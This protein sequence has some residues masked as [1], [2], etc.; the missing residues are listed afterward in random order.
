MSIRV[1]VADD[2]DMV[3]SGFRLLLAREPDI[4][5]VA[6]AADG[7]AAV[8]E[9]ARN[10]PDVVL[11]DI[12][13][14]LLDGLEA[15]R[16]IVATNPA[17]Q[18]LILTTFD[19]DAYLYEALQAGAAGFMLKDAPAADLIEAI[20][21]LARGDALLAP[22]ITRRVIAEFARRRR[23]PEARAHLDRLT[24][25]EREVLGLI[26]RGMSNAEIAA[27]LVVSA[28]TI[29]THA[30]RI[31]QKLGVRDRVQAVVTAYESGLMDEL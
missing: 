2:Q 14:P 12:R 4:D 29:K 10:A 17:A 1:L 16:Q 9:A 27:A 5:V 21:I 28:A 15:T 31:I 19:E 11:M 20:R 6:E 13:M 3:R 24:A 18:I 7:R 30:A 26:A 23:D 25:R 8:G 22:A